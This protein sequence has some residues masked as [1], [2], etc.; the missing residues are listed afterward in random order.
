MKKT[1]T[2]KS[3]LLIS[4]FCLS[5]LVFTNCKHPYAEHEHQWK[6]WVIINPITLI[7]NVNAKLTCYCSYTRTTTCTLS[8]LLSHLPENSAA[9]PYTLTVNVNSIEGLRSALSSNKTKYVSLDLSGSTITSI[10]YFDFQDCF[11]LTSVTIPNSV[12]SIGYRAFSNCT[13]L[14]SVTIPNSVTLIESSA[15]YNCT[16]LSAINVGSGNTAYSSQDGVLYNKDKTTL[17]AYPAGKSIFTIPDSV[18]SIGDSAFYGCTGLSSIT[19]P[20]NVTSIR[21]YAFSYCT[22][23]TSVTI[24]NGVTS[25]GQSTFSGCTGLTNITIPGN[26][27]NIGSSAFSGCTGL[28]AINVGSGNTAYSSQDGVL[29]NKDKTTIICYPAGKTGS[30]FT[31]PNSVTSISGYAFYG[32]TGLTSVTIGNG[33]TSISGYAFSG[34]TGLT[35]VTI[36]SSV[37][38]IGYEAFSGCTG[39]T[40][41]TFS[42]G[43]NITDANFASYAFPQGSSYND[44]RDNLKNAY[45][46]AN[47]KAGTYT[48]ASGGTEWTKQS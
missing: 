45:L 27:T 12:T 18:T 3:F 38:S 44:N 26:I 31:I 37:T 48:R 42:T 29:Y 6:E 35:S 10:G 8:E 25:I 17:V 40:S 13:G 9:T 32:C 5:A 46:A 47:P 34:C 11:G 28:S 33:V 24:G 36:P 15:F 4:V 1:N 21:D 7:T 39:L 14:T 41:V 19:I 23:L 16:G 22:G 43:S 30:I 2:I 20:G